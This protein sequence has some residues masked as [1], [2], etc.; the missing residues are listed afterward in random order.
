MLVAG[1][2]Q[3]RGHGDAQRSPGQVPQRRLQRPVAP[4]VDGDRLER[5]GV[6]GERE[7]VTAD[8]QVREGLEAVHGVAAGDPGDALVG[9]N[10]HQGGVKARARLRVPGGV[11]GRGE[12]QGE[13]LGGRWR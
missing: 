8:E 11:E 6:G 10:A 3:Q 12:R 1:A 4:G 2:A 5:P 13:P 9:V 7:R